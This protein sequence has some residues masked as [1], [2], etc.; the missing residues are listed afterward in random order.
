VSDVSTAVPDRLDEGFVRHFAH[1]WND[2]WNARDPAAAAALC[3]ED[4][5]LSMP[6][7][8]E[9]F[10][11]AAGLRAF[12]DRLATAFPDHRIELTEE[13]FISISQRKIISPW[14]FTGTMSGPWEPPGFAPTGEAIAFDGDSRIEF[15]GDRV[16]RIVD[17]YDVNDVAVKIGASP[18]PG[19]RGERLGVFLQRME[20]RRRRGRNAA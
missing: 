5:E 13:P 8:P 9:P 19:P 1:R 16:C 7:E 15:R 11:G 10:R 18:A 17:I 20:A 3:T 6:S 2:A 14:R 12:M 4:V